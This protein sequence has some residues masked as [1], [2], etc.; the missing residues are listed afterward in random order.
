MLDLAEYDLWRTGDHCHSSLFNSLGVSDMT[1]LIF[2]A[3]DPY[4]SFSAR[5]GA[6]DFE[7][8]GRTTSM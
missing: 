8:D 7:V 4:Y 6:M 5:V 2:C 1:H 3:Q